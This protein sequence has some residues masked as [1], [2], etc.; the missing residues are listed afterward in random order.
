MSCQRRW[1]KPTAVAANSGLRA[2]VRSL[3]GR[4]RRKLS[5]RS[6]QT[7]SHYELL[8]EIGAGS[9]GTVFLARDRRSHRMVALKLLRSHADRES[10]RRFLREAACATAIAHPNVVRLY[11]VVHDGEVTAI[12]MEYVRGR[13]LNHVLSNHRLALKTCLDY[14]VQIAGGLAA[15]HAAGMIDRD[16]KPAN[17]IVTKDGTVILVDFGLA[18]VIGR[19]R[20][21]SSCNRFLNAPLTRE[22]TILGTAGYMSPEQIRGKAADQRSDVFSFGVLFYEMLAGRPAFHRNSEIDAMRAILREAPPRLPARIPVRIRSI[23]RRCLAKKPG[24]RYGSATEV[25]EALIQVIR[26]L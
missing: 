6:P 13:P 5:P 11:E 2:Q 25:W 24:S 14:A 15:I 16:L 22:G 12:A 4:R 1:W 19:S 20:R 7:V 10:R 18:K 21:W 8:K 17:L 26:R 9:R 3:F 23:V